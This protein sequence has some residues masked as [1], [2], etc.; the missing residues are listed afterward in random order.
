MNVNS[1]LKK[2]VGF[3]FPTCSFCKNSSKLKNSVQAII[4]ASGYK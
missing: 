2:G 1:Y 4:V 3:N